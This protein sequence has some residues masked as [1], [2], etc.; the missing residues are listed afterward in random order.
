MLL[1]ERDKMMELTSKAIYINEELLIQE[2]R[3]LD[4]AE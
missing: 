3:F 2:K 4:A 1:A